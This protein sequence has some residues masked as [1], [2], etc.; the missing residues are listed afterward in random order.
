MWTHNSTQQQQQQQQQHQQQHQQQQRTRMPPPGFNHMNAF[1]FGVPR[2]QGMWEARV[3]FARVGIVL[4]II[5]MVS[6]AGSKILPFMNGGMQ[7]PNGQQPQ[8]PPQ[9][10]NW[11]QQ[12]QQP[13]L[14]YQQN[15][16]M[17]QPQNGLNKAGKHWRT[18]KH[19]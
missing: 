11:N 2:A 17:A 12:V 7:M 1:G 8:Q 14:G 9:N 15:E 16:H 18:K 10:G 5:A 19:W 3:F 13:F 6:F 4:L